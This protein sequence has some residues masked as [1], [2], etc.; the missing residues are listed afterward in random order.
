M[1]GDTA[2][3]VENIMLGSRRIPSCSRGRS[4]VTH[5]YDIYLTTPV[6]YQHAGRHILPPHCTRYRHI[7]GSGLH[8]CASLR[9]QP[10]AHQVQVPGPGRRP[11]RHVQRLPAALPGPRRVRVERS[12]R[13]ANKNVALLAASINATAGAGGPWGGKMQDYP[14]PDPSK[15]F[16]SCGL[17]M[18]EGQHNLR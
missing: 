12:T 7:P 3:F 9:L 4:F 13:T 17:R 16:G 5:D 6:S 1:Y 2:L 15:V 10:Q 8:H 18:M 14:G 11:R